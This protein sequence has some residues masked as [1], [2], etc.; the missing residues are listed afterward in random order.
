MSKDAEQLVR[1]SEN[2]IQSSKQLHLDSLR[3][4]E[5]TK[6]RLEDYEGSRQ[7]SDVAYKR[8]PAN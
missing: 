4:F 8:L 1:Q 5:R 6:R 3:A 7:S 2:V